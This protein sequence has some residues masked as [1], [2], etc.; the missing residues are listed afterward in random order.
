MHRNWEYSWISFASECSH[1][2]NTPFKLNSHGHSHDPRKYLVSFLP[3]S[4]PNCR[5][6]HDCDFYH[7]TFVLCT[8]EF[9]IK[10]VSSLNVNYWRTFRRGY[11]Y[12]KL[13]VFFLLMLLKNLYFLIFCCSSTV[14]CIFSTPQL[15]I[16]F[17]PF[18]QPRMGV[19]REYFEI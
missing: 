13:F 2:T 17:C 8:S 19:V 11:L 1:V 6:K 4:L 16:F 9:H 7:Y 14:V 3:L 12:Y 15:C 18:I 5:S 10:S